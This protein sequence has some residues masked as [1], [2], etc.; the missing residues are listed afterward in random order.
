MFRD[1]ATFRMIKV[2]PDA[3]KSPGIREE[4]ASVHEPFELYQVAA[5]DYEGEFP[6][7]LEV[8]W[9]PRHRHIA[10]CWDFQADVTRL[11]RD[12]KWWGDEPED[13]DARCLIDGIEEYLNAHGAFAA[14]KHFHHGRPVAVH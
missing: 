8:M 1:H 11:K 9:I 2:E 10:L 12:N 5:A 3:I 7:H 14:E 6:G 13:A 4:I